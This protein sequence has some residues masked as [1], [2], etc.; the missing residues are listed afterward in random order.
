MESIADVLVV[1]IVFGAIF[2][3]G[4]VKLILNHR[5]EVRALEI[6]ERNTMSQEEQESLKKQIGELKRRVEV[7]ERIVTD[8][9]YQ[10]EKEI[11]SL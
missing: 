10:L 11:A 9:K 4:I 3:G 7:L 6:S 8:S 1:A 2:G 5:K